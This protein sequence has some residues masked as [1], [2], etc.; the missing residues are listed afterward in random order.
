MHAH[1]YRYPQRPPTSD[2]TEAGVTGGG[3]LSSVS[4]GNLTQVLYKDRT[5]FTATPSLWSPF[6][7]KSHCVVR[8]GL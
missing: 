6:F 1:E 5:L 4:A 3:E 7:L 2:R 8:A